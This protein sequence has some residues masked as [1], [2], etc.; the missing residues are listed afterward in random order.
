MCSTRSP[1]N[2]PGCATTSSFLRV[3]KPSTRTIISPSPHSADVS[4]VMPAAS[5]L[6]MARGLRV[7]LCEKF[8]PE[9]PGDGGSRF[10]K[11]S[12]CQP[13]APR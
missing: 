1:P 11:T 5:R 10:S 7:M 9:R 3:Q 13:C 6:A 4:G 12:T 2:N 8:C